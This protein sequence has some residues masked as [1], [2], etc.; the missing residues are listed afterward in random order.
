MTTSIDDIDF[1]DHIT[2]DKYLNDPDSIDIFD[3]SI[4][5][6]VRIK[7]I[8]TLHKDV[9]LEYVNKLNSM[10]SVSGTTLIH[11]FIT[12]LCGDSSTISSNLKVEC[13]KC[14]CLKNIEAI[15]NFNLLHTI[16]KEHHN[17]P[18]P[19]RV[20]A[21]IF[22]TKSHTFNH[23]L[24]ISL[25][26]S[27]IKDYMIE[28]DYK[29]KMI[30]SLEE[31]YNL[32]KKKYIYPLLMIF[33]KFSNMLTT[34]RILSCQRLLQYFKYELVD[35]NTYS[36]I[37][38]I[39]YSFST[40]EELDY[41]LRADSTDV[42][43]GLGDEEHK[44][45]ARE[46]LTILGSRKYTIYD[47]Q[48]NVHNVNIDES[49]NDILNV[50]LSHK[51][52]DDISFTDI[53]NTCT[54]KIENEINTLQSKLE[55][56]KLALNRINLDVSL[57]GNSNLTL[58]SVLLYLYNYISEHEYE[59]TLIERLKEELEDASGKCSTGYVKRLLNVLSGFDDLSIKIGH[60]DAIIGK[61]SGRL[62]KMIG[63]IEDD[64][65]KDQILLEMT[66][67]KD[68][69]I[70]DRSTFLKYFRDNIGNIKD[71]I[72]EEVKNDI[73]KVDYEIYFRKAMSV[74]EG[75]DFV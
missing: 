74:Y 52:K 36:L 15:E 8:N 22:L 13:A 51:L 16:L 57:Y 46:M 47:D 23:K 72:W 66:M 38:N 58:K 40:D 60:D 70:L 1:D 21:I 32:D 9:Q 71:D 65:E 37:Q 50:L 69:Q 67:T 14:L 49:S 3:M 56:I 59:E 61:L 54:N 4:P 20:L 7:V 24:I 44:K 5:S 35:N 31:V 30:V 17:I 41:N 25:F 48:Q 26:E 45:L 62:N 68:S 2:L 64:E 27:I 18:I 42:L 28:C 63:E 43:L 12:D 10:Y 6:D 34:Y 19:C 39:L 73:T 53:Y 55:K 33:S 11:S 75:I 29:Y